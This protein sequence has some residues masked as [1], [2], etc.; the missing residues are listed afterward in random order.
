MGFCDSNYAGDQDDR[1][2][3]SGYVFLLGSEAVLWSS[4]KQSIVT[5]STTEAE[6]VT[7]TSC[8]CQAIW[9]NKIL[10]ELKFSRIMSLLQFIVIIV[11][12]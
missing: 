9:L 12:T 1:K 2:S 3:T 5:L 8:A 10:E 6:F 4:K 7:A 11:Q